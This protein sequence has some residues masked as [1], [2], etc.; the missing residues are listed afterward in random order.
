MKPAPANAQAIRIQAR[1]G[2][3]RR[4]QHRRSAS[5]ALGVALERP[6]AVATGL[7]HAAQGLERHPG[8]RAVT[9][10]GDPLQRVLVLAGHGAAVAGR[11]QRRAHPPGDACDALSRRVVQ[12]R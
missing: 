12:D 11:A 6:A 2:R 4:I 1:H 10:G 3:S 8:G 9:L 5:Q 7:R